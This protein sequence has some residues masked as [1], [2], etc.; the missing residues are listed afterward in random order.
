MP[1]KVSIVEDQLIYQRRLKNIL[2]KDGSFT[3]NGEFSDGSEILKYSNDVLEDVILMDLEMP[4]I[5]GREASAILLK[6][7]P[8]IKI[9]I[10][11]LFN[12]PSYIISLNKLGVKKRWTLNCYAWRLNVSALV[13]FAVRLTWRAKS[14]KI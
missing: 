13:A 2:L 12:E 3:I 4:E 8:S 14:R 5:D 1:I 9:I 7:Y 10:L 6:Q 11:T